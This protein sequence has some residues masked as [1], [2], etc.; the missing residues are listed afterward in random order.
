MNRL[1]KILFPHVF[2]HLTSIYK[3]IQQRL[4]PHAITHTGVNNDN[5]AL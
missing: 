3:K 4:E 2:T 5:M 1:T